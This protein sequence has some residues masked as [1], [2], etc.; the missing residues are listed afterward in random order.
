MKNTLSY[1]ITVLIW[2]STWLA[3]EFQLGDVDPAVSLVYRF[4]IAAILIWGWCLARKLPM[5]FSLVDHSFLLLLATCNF[6]FNYLILYWAQ[7]YLTSAMTSIAFSTLLLMNICNTRLFF[8]KPISPRIYA[9]A[10]LGI[11]GILCLFWHD[12]RELDFASEAMYGL[13]LAL[14]GTLVASFG[15][16]TSVRN[17]RKQIGIVQGNAWGMLYGT[18]ILAVYAQLSG[19]EFNFSMKFEYLASL[20]YLSVLGTVVAFGSYFALLKNIGPEKASY[21]I[22]LFPVVAVIL[23]SFY[24]GFAWYASSV[25]G[26]ALVLIGNAIVLTPAHVLNRFVFRHVQSGAN[27]TSKITI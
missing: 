19:A 24:D 4:F 25:I 5:R 22:V 1:L 12:V 15:N 6:A 2:G 8:G 17:S 16:M 3:I 27:H 11:V 7:V 14:L 26:F 23:G 9:G 10:V 20:V 21:T 13:G 18:V